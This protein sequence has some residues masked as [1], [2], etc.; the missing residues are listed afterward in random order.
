M[1][2]GAAVLQTSTNAK[3]LEKKATEKK[4]DVKKPPVKKDASK[5]DGSLSLDC[6]H[7]L[8]YVLFIILMRSST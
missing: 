1:G 7:V 8:K 5:S 3:N 6:S 4:D 2:T